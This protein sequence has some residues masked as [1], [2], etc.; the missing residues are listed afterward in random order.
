MGQ[1]PSL[2]RYKS[3][4]RFVNAPF[5]PTGKRSAARVVLETLK[6]YL[7]DYEKGEKGVYEL[8]VAQEKQAINFAKKL[9]QTNQRVK[10]DNPSTLVY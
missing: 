9:I 8:L 2:M 5:A 4:F 7:P 3:G 6:N 10:T 1:F